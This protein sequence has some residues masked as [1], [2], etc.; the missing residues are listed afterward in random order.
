MRQNIPSMLHKTM[1]TYVLFALSPC[2]TSSVIFVM[3][4][5]ITICMKLQ[6]NFYQVV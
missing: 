3:N 5:A 6:A 2:V 1:D 4:V